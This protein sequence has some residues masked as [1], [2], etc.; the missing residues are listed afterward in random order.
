MRVNQRKNSR[1]YR[2]EVV[3]GRD[4][5]GFV[6][7]ALVLKSDKQRTSTRQAAYQRHQFDARERETRLA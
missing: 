2:G 4:D 3:S 1:L 5:R 6:Q 7:K